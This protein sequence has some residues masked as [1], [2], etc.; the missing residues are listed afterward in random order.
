MRTGK[1]DILRT[2]SVCIPWYIKWKKNNLCLELLLLLL[3][4]LVL[5][6]IC[7][8]FNVATSDLDLTVYI[9]IGRTEKKHKIRKFEA[10]KSLTKVRKP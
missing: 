3:L 2:Y 9:P 6:Y 7:V 10:K 8:C 5:L 4:F 1:A